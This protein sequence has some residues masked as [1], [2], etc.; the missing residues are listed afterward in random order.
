MRDPITQ[1][2]SLLCLLKPA[3]K[4]DDKKNK[5]NFVMV[6]VMNGYHDGSKRRINTDGWIKVGGAGR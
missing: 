6:L 3:T 5:K 2:L 4:V 1:I